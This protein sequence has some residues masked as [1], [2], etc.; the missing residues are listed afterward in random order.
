M[1]RFMATAFLAALI[2]AP[3][4][5]AGLAEIDR[6][7]YRL[8]FDHV[9]EL[10]GLTR[11]EPL[12]VLVIDE[13]DPKKVSDAHIASTRD[14]VRSGGVVWAVGEGL[15]SVLVR[16]LAPFNVRKFDY[17]KTGTGKRGGELLVR[18]SSPRLEIHDVPLSEGVDELYLFPKRRFNGTRDALPV[19]EMTDERGNHGLVIAAV[20]VGRGLLVLDGTARSRKKLPVGRLPGFDPDH[21]NAVKQ[22]GVW[23]NYDWPRL[24]ANAVEWADEAL[25]RRR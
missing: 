13:K 7:V 1:R 16:A 20:P 17:K 15:E 14:W 2:A 3:A 21:P 19:V 25:A 23:R 24:T 9:D 12:R 4:A 8:T 11:D 10:L 18:G 5:Q 22:S 6:G